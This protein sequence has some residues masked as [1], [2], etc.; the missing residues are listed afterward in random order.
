MYLLY[1]GFLFWERINVSQGFI[2]A[3]FDCFQVFSYLRKSETFS[4]I[5]EYILIHDMSVE[6]RKRW[7][8]SN[9]KVS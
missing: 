8:N 4:M 5:G 1:K 6:L 9:K 7:E 2:E 3:P